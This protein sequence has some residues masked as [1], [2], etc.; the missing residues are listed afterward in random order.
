MAPIALAFGVLALPGAD[1]SSLGLVLLCAA[2]PRVLFMLLG[3]VV[4]DRVRD[5]ARLMAVAEAAAMTAQLVAGALFLSGRATVPAL[6]ALAVVNGTAVAL[7]YPT[8]TGLVPQLATGDALQ[9]ANALIRMSTAVAGIIGTALGGILVAAVGAGWALVVDGATYGLSALLLLLVRSG[10]A[11]TRA[12]GDGSSVLDDLLHG[13]R[14]FT[15]RRWVWLL[16][17]LFSLSNFGFTAAIG[18]LGPV[19]ALES[20]DGAPSWALVMASFTAGTL[21]GVLVA[22]RLRPARP[23]L[24]ALLAELLVAL[25]VFALAVP[26]P[27]PV[28]V[29]LAF[30]SGVGVDVFE[31][32][33]QTTLQQQVPAESLSRVSAYDWFGSLALTPFALA[34]AGPLAAAIGLGPAIAV[35]AALGA[36]SCLALLDPQV[37]RVRAAPAPGAAATAM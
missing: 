37:R 18:V 35:C 32:L 28:I 6:A 3:G 20:F 12:K 27:L 11:T 25:P 26:A 14:E 9:S 5:R 33:W 24:T 21:A 19:R 30:L 8:M 1:A 2:L 29:G 23:L 15:A 13:W 36:V 17:A 7:F 34:A 31:V 22:M 4:A 16:V 10:R